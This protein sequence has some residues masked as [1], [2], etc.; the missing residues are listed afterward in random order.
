[1]LT[2]RIQ[3]SALLPDGCSVFTA[4]LVAI[5]RALEH[6]CTCRGVSYLVCSDSLS[7]LQAIDLCYTRHP[8]VATIQESVY[9]LERSGR[10][11]VFVWTTGHVGI[12]GNELVDRL[13]KLA[14]RKP[15][16]DIGVPE[17]DHRSVLH[18]KVLGIWDAEWHS[19]PA[20]NKLRTIKEHTT[21]WRSSL[22]ASRRDSVVLCRLRIGHTWLT[23]GFLLRHEDPPC[24]RYGSRLTVAHILVDCPLLAA[25]RRHFNLS[26]S[27]QSILGDDAS[28]ANLVLSFIRDAGFY[29]SV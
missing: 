15:L 24:C 25:Q 29:S 17:C 13:A 5:S 4:E 26:D 21:A 3:N 27:L 10:S 2:R 7:G 12:T 11:V 19:L 6:I 23:H 22:L 28:T 14:T 9:A 1:M 8:L 18:H 20:V 16:L